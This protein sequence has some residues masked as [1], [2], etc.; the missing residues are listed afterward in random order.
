M[1]FTMNDERIETNNILGD[2]TIRDV[3]LKITQGRGGVYLYGK[4]ERTVS[5]VTVWQKYSRPLNSW[6]LMAELRNVGIR[7]KVREDESFEFEDLFDFFPKKCEWE[8]VPLGQELPPGVRAKPPTQSYSLAEYQNKSGNHQPNKR[9]FEYEGLTEVYAVNVTH[10]RHVY[11]PHAAGVV[12]EDSRLRSAVSTWV[13]NIRQEVYLLPPKEST[14]DLTLLFSRVHATELVPHVSFGKLL[15]TF[16]GSTI[17]LN[18]PTRGVSFYLKRKGACVTFLPDGSLK[19]VNTDANE[20]NPI[21]HY[22]NQV[23]RWGTAFESDAVL[24][25]QKLAFT[26]LF[27][28]AVYPLW[29][30]NTKERTSIT[31][32]FEGPVKSTLYWNETISPT[33]EYVRCTPNARIVFCKGEVHVTNLPT[34]CV[35]FASRYVEAW[36]TSASD[37]PTEEDYSC[38]VAEVNELEE[39]QTMDAYDVYVSK[40]TNAGYDMGMRYKGGVLSMDEKGGYGFLPCPTV[41]KNVNEAFLNEWVPSLSF[42]ET[43]QFLERAARIAPTTT[44]KECVINCKGYCVGVRTQGNAFVRCKPER[45]QETHGLRKTTEH[46][47]LFPNTGFVYGTFR[48]LIRENGM[49]SDT[50]KYMV[51]V[52]DRTDEF[53]QWQEGKLVLTF[54]EREQ[55]GSMLRNDMARFQHLQSYMLK[56]TQEVNGF[57]LDIRNEQIIAL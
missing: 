48:D 39:T 46:E 45:T 18:D 15:R 23:L 21:I 10:L 16:D 6:E 1:L 42:K 3:A 31:A 13:W 34:E 47:I 20:T 14:I 22:A 24:I 50:T 36:L 35:T 52:D 41:S 57:T 53:P 44:P 37:E 25:G 40:F 49:K 43:I 27:C 38:S 55:F 9:L 56:Q 19:C 32:E 5:A 7:R 30:S 33:M 28:D 2:D 26:P 12:P 54:K 17:A 29:K 4:V 51:C 11:L 8:L